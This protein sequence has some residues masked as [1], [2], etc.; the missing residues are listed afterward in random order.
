LKRAADE[1]AETLALWRDLEGKARGHIAVAGFFL[2]AAFAS[3]GA[4]K[5]ETPPFER[6]MI[7]LAVLAVCT[8]ILTAF[9]ALVTEK[10]RIHRLAPPFT[11]KLSI[12]GAWKLKNRKSAFT[13]YA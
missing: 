11:S 1:Y 7:A 6:W 13:V 4:V 3:A 10:Q 12:C 2:A 5:A 9:A 8:T